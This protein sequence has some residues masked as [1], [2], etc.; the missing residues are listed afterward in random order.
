MYLKRHEIITFLNVLDREFP[1]DLSSQ[2]VLQVPQVYKSALQ[3]HK[4]ADVLL[5]VSVYGFCLL[6]LILYMFTRD[7]NGP[8]TVQQQLLG[9]YLP[10]GLRESHKAYP[11]AWFYDV[12]CTVNGVSYFST[13]D[14]MFYSM[15]EQ[16]LMHLDCLT[17]Q[18]T[19]VNWTSQDDTEL[20][21][22]ICQLI[23]RHQYLNSLCDQFNY[24]F[25]AAIM[26]TDLIAATSICFHLF[27][28]TETDDHFLMLRYFIPIVGL[29]L[30]TFEVCHR[31]AQLEEAYLQLNAKLYNQKWYLCSKKI[32]KLILI[33]LKYTQCTK[34]L[35]AYGVM[36]LNMGHFTDVRM[37]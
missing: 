7:P 16:I 10:F 32:R 14:T 4:Y 18:L 36:E 19:K 29:I 12:L 17:R 23:R 35:N 1:H 3:R 21:N 5:S 8:I 30:F 37:T 15:H 31:G 26:I 24:I 2:A 28:M 11:L 27:L 13:F 6:A 33:W 9:G 25:N 34:K 22:E 20:Y